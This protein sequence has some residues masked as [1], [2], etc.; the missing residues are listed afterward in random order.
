MEEEDE[1]EEEE[2]GQQ[3]E[4]E[5]TLDPEIFGDT[6]NFRTRSPGFPMPT[7]YY[8]KIGERSYLNERG[9]P[10]LPFRAPGVRDGSIEGMV[11]MKTGDRFFR[12]NDEM[13]SGKAWYGLVDGETLFQDA[14]TG[15]LLKLPEEQDPGFAAGLDFDPLDPPPDVKIDMED[16]NTEQRRQRL[17]QAREAGRAAAQAIRGAGASDE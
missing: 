3:G 9:E 5:D 4:T 14:A 1:E 15:N 11:N 16:L 2:Q 8:K 12:Q 7:G 13:T 10:W 6:R 17:D